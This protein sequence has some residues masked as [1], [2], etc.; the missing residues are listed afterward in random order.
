MLALAV[1]DPHITFSLAN[2]AIA[3]L[4]RRRIN[5]RIEIENPPSA[6]PANVPLSM[7]PETASG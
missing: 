2:A 1:A 3:M 7:K 4:A 5:L 6:M